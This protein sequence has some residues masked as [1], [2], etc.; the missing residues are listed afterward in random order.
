[1]SF[2]SKKHPNLFSVGPVTIQGE[3]KST[4]LKS[5]RIE[6]HDNK[7]EKRASNTSTPE[8]SPEMH[9]KLIVIAE[10]ILK[11]WDLDIENIEVADIDQA[12]LVWKIT[13]PEGPVGLKRIS[14]PEKKALFSIYAQNY[15]V[16]K[17]A[18]VPSILITKKQQLYARQ[19]P[20]LFVV[21][22][23]IDGWP[24]DLTVP[25]DVRRMMQGVAEY[26]Q[27]SKGFHPP[28][29]IPDVSKLGQWPRQ[30]VKQ[31]RQLG[32]GKVIA[33]S[34]PREA[35]SQLYLDVADEFIELGKE[36]FKQLNAS[37]YREWVKESKP[38][39]MLCHQD[40]ESNTILWGDDHKTW[41]T[42]LDSASFDLP[43]SDLRR[44]MIPIQSDV[45]TWN[46]EQFDHMLSAYEVVNPLTVKQK[47]VM[48]IDMM[49]PY[50]FY[51][52]ARE[53]FLLE[54]DIPAVAL[55]EAAA[56]ERLKNEMLMEK[57]TDL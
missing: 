28:E 48:F 31:Y 3:V 24:F 10:E 38:N 55:E 40:F 1:V 36:A 44:I 13:T 50:E 56:F 14:R 33:K 30:Y 52:V 2:L 22:D 45:G 5:A 23:W 12:R 27:A 8:L 39:P 53:K 16:E 46:D 32:W 11:E 20:F 19:G 6:F 29:T 42:D 51:E 49:F 17:G 57:L 35:F 21:H 37:H 9:K 7:E 4:F 34:K 25:E 18:H 47:E 54:K 26:H 41:I 43:I 15:L